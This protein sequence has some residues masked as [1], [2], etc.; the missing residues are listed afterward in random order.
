MYK[1]L[2]LVQ[3]KC[4]KED[5]AVYSVLSSHNEDLNF[6]FCLQHRSLCLMPIIVWPDC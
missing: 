3:V 1:G 6:S 5:N 2:P 4:E